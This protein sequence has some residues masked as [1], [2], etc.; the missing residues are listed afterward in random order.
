MYGRNNHKSLLKY[1]QVWDK[2]KN[3]NLGHCQTSV[4]KLHGQVQYEVKVFYIP[5]VA[6]VTIFWC[7][8]TLHIVI[9]L[10]SK[11]SYNNYTTSQHEFLELIASLH[12]KGQNIF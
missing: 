5:A 1:I 8:T 6:S 12:W 4:I 11:K 10:P 7:L 3:D 2:D 9:C